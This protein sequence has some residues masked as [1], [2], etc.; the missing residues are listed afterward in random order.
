MTSTAHKPKRW[1]RNDCATDEFRAA[2]R[3]KVRKNHNSAFRCFPGISPGDQQGRG[4]NSAF[5][6]IELLVVI[7]I[8][9]LLV[10]IL[11]PSLMKAKELA[12]QTQC[13]ALL[14]Q[15]DLAIR[16]YMEDN[17]GWTA[18][19]PTGSGDGWHVNISGTDF[20]DGGSNTIAVSNF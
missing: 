4:K 8:L 13:M 1:T 14:R 9:S 18:I 11:L 12:M 20:S 16:Y 3:M 5:T 15:W 10:S 7:A 2:V 19:D 17:D 6:L